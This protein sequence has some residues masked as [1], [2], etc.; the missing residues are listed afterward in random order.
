M[1][2]MVKLQ[3]YDGSWQGASMGGPLD[4]A[5]GV[6]AGGVGQ[7]ACVSPPLGLASRA[8]DVEA[9]GTLRR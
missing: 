6:C 9:G 7:A 8:G 3:G 1:D 5:P 4:L 2:E